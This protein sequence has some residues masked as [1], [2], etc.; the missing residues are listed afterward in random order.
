[1]MPKQVHGKPS[2]KSLRWSMSQAEMAD[3]KLQVAEVLT[4]TRR[5][6]LTLATAGGH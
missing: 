4:A 5:I 2:T 6:E 1:M 3:L